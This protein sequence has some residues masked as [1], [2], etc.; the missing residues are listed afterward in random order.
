VSIVSSQNFLDAH[1]QVDGTRYCRQVCTDSAGGSHQQLLRLSPGDDADARL[2]D[3]AARLAVSL[4]EQEYRRVVSLDAPIVL[5]HQ[6]KEELAARF[7]QELLE[8]YRDVDKVRM[9]YLIWWVYNQFSDG[10]FTSNQLR[11]TFNAAYERSLNVSQWNALV[12][13]RLIPIH[14]RYQAMLDEAEL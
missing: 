7:W 4:A 14:D 5:A 8:A 10:D 6:T 13:N 11:L 12:T 3:Y 1:T 2:A 9:G